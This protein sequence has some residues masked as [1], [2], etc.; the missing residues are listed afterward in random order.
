[1]KLHRVRIVLTVAVWLAGIS[2]SWGFDQVHLI[3][4]EGAKENLILGSISSISPEEVVIEKNSVAQPPIA[5]NKIKFIQFDGEGPLFN[6]HTPIN[7]GDFAEAL[8]LL[9]KIQPE[10]LK[11]GQIKQELEYL[12]AFCEGR[13]ALGGGLPVAE[14]KNP[15]AEAGKRMI[16]FVNANPKSYHFYE[17]NEIVGDLLVANGNFSTAVQ[18]YNA[19]KKAPWPDYRMRADV[20][21]GRALLAQGKTTEAA[22]AFDDVAF[23]TEA[24][25]ELAEGQRQ[26]AK[27]GKARC[28]AAGGKADQAIK[29]V[30]EIIAK[31]DPEN[32]D[33]HAQ[34][35]NALGEALRK[36]NKPKEALLA[37]LHTDLLYAASPDS[38]AEAL[39]NLVALF[40]ELH[41]PDHANRARATLRER[42]GASRWAQGQR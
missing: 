40:D 25:D 41:K 11:T 12:T 29:I 26:A 31:A 37:Y 10:D 9:E 15:L 19:L 27:L 36:S 14:G 2:L 21:L 20:A 42:Y 13:L 23:N 38:H 4:K 28:L 8:S 24:T 1:M 3:G 35:Y 7:N 17:A 32:T 22:K 18:Y 30:E 39:A 33:L 34:A 16:A 5:V 6:V